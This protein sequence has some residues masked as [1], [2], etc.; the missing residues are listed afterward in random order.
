MN[1]IIEFPTDIKNREFGFFTFGNKSMIR[2][3]SFKSAEELKIFLEKTV[4]CDAFSSSAYYEHPTAKMN[5]KAWFGADLIFDIDADHIPTSCNKTHDQW[6]CRDCGHAD[7]GRVPEK[8]P[9]CKSQKLDVNSWPCEICLNSAKRET[10]Q[11]VDML[12]QDF[13]FPE[14]EMHVFF[15]G[16]RG[17]HVHVQNEEFKRSDTIARKEVVD[18][19]C[20][21]GFDLTLHGFDI[22]GVG[23][24]HAF[25]E[26][27]NNFGWRRRIL[28]CMND[29]TREPNR[30]DYR[31]AD[32]KDISVLSA[33][34]EEKKPKEPRS[35]RLTPSKPARWK[36]AIECCK[37]SVSAKI[38]TVVT[39][40]VHRLIRLPNSLHS[41]TGL[42]KV[43]FPLS[44][45][46]DFDPF[47]SAVALKKSA[48]RVSV[49]NSPE[50]RLGEET[51]GPYKSQK[52]ELPI[53]AAVLLVCKDR[54]EVIE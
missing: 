40:D 54:A 37:D 4:P 22:K 7:K 13:G 23:P 20:G 19:I 39:T 3:L 47:K 46:N 18:Y 35:E 27:L 5:E 45:V 29:P 6:I 38:D 42:R 2:H 25:S 30:K 8:C 41:K 21:L 24:K 36:K 32:M 52:V 26:G 11:L 28:S 15:S 48:V 17:Y 1:S 53:A 10:S 44:S 34:R 43:E 9:E 51:F 31:A 50:F 16:H 14:E 12:T 33:K 49:F